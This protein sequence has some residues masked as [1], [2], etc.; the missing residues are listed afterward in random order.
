MSELDCG[1]PSSRAKAAS[2]HLRM[3]DR[4]P[5]LGKALSLDTTASQDPG[6]RIR[7]AEAPEPPDPARTR[8]R[9]FQSSRTSRT[10]S[11]MNAR[12]GCR[13]RL[14]ANRQH[15]CIQPVRRGRAREQRESHLASPELQQPRALS[16]LPLPA[17]ATT[18]TPTFHPNESPPGP[19]RHHGHD[20]APLSAHVGSTA[21]I[22]SRRRAGAAEGLL[23]TNPTRNALPPRDYLGTSYRTPTSHGGRPG[24]ERTP[25]SGNH[26]LEARPGMAVA[27]SPLGTTSLPKDCRGPPASRR[28]RMAPLARPSQHHALTSPTQISSIRTH[29][30]RI[31]AIDLSVSP[32]V[33][34]LELSCVVLRERSDR[35]PC[36]LQR[37]S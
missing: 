27:S 17:Q 15:A 3:M 4:P 35:G 29:T 26:S 9:T 6:T 14:S 11:L 23:H 16:C 28:G 12:A 19:R 2:P 21:P 31:N 22:P 1:S 34:R 25:L 7:R 36:Q 5:W 30:S 33:Q 20:L 24:E 37:P 32:S 8:A 13:E 10:T 18:A